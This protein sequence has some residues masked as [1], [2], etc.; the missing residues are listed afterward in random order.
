MAGLVTKR[1]YDDVA[2]GPL[3]CELTCNRKSMINAHIT[4]PSYNMHLTNR[5][6]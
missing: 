5:L 3:L 1:L 6:M 4:P 2:T